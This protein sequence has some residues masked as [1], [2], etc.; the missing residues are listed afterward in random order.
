M[1][2]FVDNKL[3][4][5]LKPKLTFFSFS[6]KRPAKLDSSRYDEVIE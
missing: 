2:V 6:F 3:K 1:A 5:K 4:L